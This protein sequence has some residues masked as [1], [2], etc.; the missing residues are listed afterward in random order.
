M[1]ETGFVVRVVQRLLL[2][3][4]QSVAMRVRYMKLHTG[5]HLQQWH[6]VSLI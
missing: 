5:L 4:E 6:C 2:F 1:E 3:E